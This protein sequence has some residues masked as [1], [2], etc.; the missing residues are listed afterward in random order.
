MKKL[1]ILILILLISVS[2]SQENNSDKYAESITSNELSE[3]LYEFASDEFEGRN[4]GEPGQK[5]AVNFIRDFYKANDI[6]KADNTED[7]FQKFLVDF[8]KR[9]V[10]KPNNIN[11]LESSSIDEENIDWVKTE[12]V[13][14]IIKGDVYPNEYIVLTAHLDHVGIEDGEI[15]N[16]ADDDGSG[17]MALLEIAQAFK[18]AELDGNRPKRSIVILHVSAEEKGLLGSKYYA[19]NPLYPLN[20]TI[21]NLNVDMIGRTDPTRES[22]NDNYI[23]LIGTDRL[24]SMLHETSEKVNSRTVNLELD[25]R[26]NAWDDPNRFYE[27]SDH[28]NFAKNNIPVI[29]YFS[30][31]H[32]DYH[33]PGDTPDKIRYDLLTQRSR[34]IFHTAWE[35]ANMDI[36]IEVDQK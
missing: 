9:Q 26:F 33:G 15:Y 22:D 1:N 13:A 6:V 2:C 35:I 20:E 17:S 36:S 5:L 21:T 11:P 10:A 28:F 16:G 7:Y 4:T 3:L 14:A 30:G 12:N 18:L 27:R 25:Y 34:L 23:Y 31:T 24:S 29:F 32:E 8:S 19:E